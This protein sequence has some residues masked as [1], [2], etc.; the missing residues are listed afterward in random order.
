[1]DKHNWI[2]DNADRDDIRNYITGL[3][4]RDML[5][6]PSYITDDDGECAECRI[7]HLVECP[8]CQEVL[9]EDEKPTYCPNCGQRLD[10]SGYGAD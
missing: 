10:W 3:I 1:M 8:R 6:P 7:G 4:S 2:L 9:D 5:M